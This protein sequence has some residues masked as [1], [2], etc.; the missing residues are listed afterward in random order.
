MYEVLNGMRKQGVEVGEKLLV[1][2]DQMTRTPMAVQTKLLLELLE[3]NQNTEY[4]KKYGFGDIKSIE[5]YQQR[6]PITDYDDY[7]AYI[8][9]MVN[10]G[11]KNLTCANKPV[12]YN[13]TSGTVGEPKKIPYTQRTRDCFMRY[14]LRYQTGLLHGELGEKFFGGRSLNLIRCG[15]EIVRLPDGTPFGPISEASLRPYLPKWQHIFP[16][17]SQAAFAPKGTDTRYL[18]ARYSLCDRDLNNINC[19]FTG[20]LLDLCRYIE[21]NWRLLVNDIEKGVIDESVELPEEIR[22]SLTAE[23]KPL[24]DRAAELRESLKKALTPP[25]CLRSGPS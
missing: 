7:A 23:L 2:F 13:K 10:N 16:T 5:E 18:N 8:D 24:P 9:R 20:F 17:P 6:V 12:W 22:E 19:T 3:E 15:G 4:G 25:L 21:K 1:A 14:S 11:E